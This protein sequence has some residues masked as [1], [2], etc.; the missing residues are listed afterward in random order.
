M[1]S[2]HLRRGQGSLKPLGV[3]SPPQP[4]N[5]DSGSS[6][7]G[8]VEGFSNNEGLQGLVVNPSFTP[9]PHAGT[10]PFTLKQLSADPTTSYVPGQE[11]IDPDGRIDVDPSSSIS[12]SAGLLAPSQEEIS[13]SDISGVYTIVPFITVSKPITLYRGFV[14]DAPLASLTGI[15][16]Q[17]L[18]SRSDKVSKIPEGANFIVAFGQ[19][20]TTG[21]WTISHLSTKGTTGPQ[22]LSTTD[23]QTYLFTLAKTVQG[24]LL[25]YPIPQRSTSGDPVD[26]LG[27]STKGPQGWAVWLDKKSDVGKKANITSP[28]VFISAVNYTEFQLCQP[29]DDETSITLRS[30]TKKPRTLRPGNP[31]GTATGT[32][33]HWWIWLILGLVVIFVA[34][35]I[36]IA[37]RRTR[38]R[39]K[40]KSVEMEAPAP[41]SL[42]LEVS[43][44]EVKEDW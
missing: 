5:D 25:T 11:S 26:A 12:T 34:G 2:S 30:V 40:T 21:K 15:T 31:N 22:S 44:V 3:T 28:F 39:K 8:E 32:T 14:T 17:Y 18:N 6:W 41:Q 4:L 7:K 37:I 1:F 23:L 24:Y 36:I 43:G 33:S 27:I 38:K 10:H 13:V 20:D 29:S 19:H 42:S 35:G 16:D 9:S